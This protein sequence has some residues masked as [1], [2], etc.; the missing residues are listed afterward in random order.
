MEDTK[1]VAGNALEKLEVIEHFDQS[2]N[3]GVARFVRDRY[4]KIDERP[5]ILIDTIE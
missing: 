2:V 3:G 4:G 1:F 5:E